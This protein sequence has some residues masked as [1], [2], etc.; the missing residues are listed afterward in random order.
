M[1][2]IFFLGH[3]EADKY[4]VSAFR[5]HFAND[6]LSQLFLHIAS[7]DFRPFGGKHP[8]VSGANAAGS[9]GN[10]HNFSR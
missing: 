8:Y 2:P 1:Y 10:Q 4:G 6:Y 3:I 9:T 7:D 5:A